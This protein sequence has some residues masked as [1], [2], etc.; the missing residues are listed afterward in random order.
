MGLFQKLFD[1]TAE[2]GKISLPLIVWGIY[3]GVLIAIVL[4]LVS[5][6][7]SY[8]LIYALICAKAFD[9]ESAQTFQ[10]LGIKNLFIYKLIFRR[11]SPLRKY[12]KYDGK[13][14]YL[15]EE[16]RIGAEVRFSKER[17]PVMT[18]V[19]AAVALFIVACFVI[20]LLP[21]ILDAYRT[22]WQ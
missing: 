7:Y 1:F 10:D 6:V 22:V 15:P 2:A 9:R 3:V 12:I 13:E 19:F 16:R 8:K 14:M 21:Q 5:R 18:F 11:S 4:S 20:V 17:H